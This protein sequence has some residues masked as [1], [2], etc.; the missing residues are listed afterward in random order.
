MSSVDPAIK[1]YLVEALNAMKEEYSNRMVNQR[2]LL[3][4]EAQT[5]QT[6]LLRALE[7]HNQAVSALR[8]ENSQ[9]INSLRTAVDQVAERGMA[10]SRDLA[11]FEALVW[12]SGLEDAANQI[13]ELQRKVDSTARVCDLMHSR[14]ITA[15]IGEGRH[16]LPAVSG[17]PH[18]LVPLPPPPGVLRSA[19]NDA[20]AKTKITITLIGAA[21]TLGPSI[22]AFLTAWLM[23]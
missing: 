14:E 17:P 6:E 1:L 21:V 16:P 9:L 5:R 22:L 4:T 12:S 18:M 19:W 13:K 3:N 11:R 10:N 23:K 15:A 2:E 20:E 7:A 8:A